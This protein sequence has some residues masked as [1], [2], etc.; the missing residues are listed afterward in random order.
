MADDLNT[1]PPGM[2]VTHSDVATV[3]VGDESAA[4]GDKSSYVDDYNK[5]MRRSIGDKYDFI[6]RQIPDFDKKVGLVLDFGCGDGE[7]LKRIAARDKT[8]KLTRQYIGV[9][10]APEMIHA[11]NKNCA[12]INALFTSNFEEARASVEATH[13]KGKK[14]VLVLSSVVHEIMHYQSPEQQEKFWKTVW[15]MGTDYVAIR[16]FSLPGS[17]K[18]NQTSTKVLNSIRR[19]YADKTYPEGHPLAGRNILDVWQNGF[20]PMTGHGPEYEKGFKGW[21]PIENEFSAIHFLMSFN[22][23]EADAKDPIL[24]REGM[25]ELQENYGLTFSSLISHIPIIYNPIYAERGVTPARTKILKDTFG[26]SVRKDDIPPMKIKTVV[27]RRSDIKDP[28]LY[29]GRYHTS[30]SFIGKLAERTLQTKYGIKLATDNRYPERDG[31]GILGRFDGQRYGGSMD[32]VSYLLK[33]ADRT[34]MISRDQ[35]TDIAL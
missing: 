24:Q 20:E 1:L 26:I 29:E 21:G 17:L 15:S 9:D 5:G 18:Y 30:L 12:N 8:M 13:A 25:R 28:S 3:V 16:D 14:S 33:K 2:T 27:E 11:A 32:W 19:A 10:V 31:G 7:L 23:L 4:L 6:V 34:S 22:R 35:G